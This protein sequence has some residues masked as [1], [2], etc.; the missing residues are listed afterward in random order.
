MKIK[1]VFK[2]KKK[3]IIIIVL[4][5][6]LLVILGVFLYLNNSSLVFQN[7]EDEVY[8]NYVGVSNGTSY[9]KDTADE[10]VKETAKNEGVAFENK[11][12]SENGL[13]QIKPSVGTNAL[14]FKILSKKDDMIKIIAFTSSNLC[15]LSYTV[16][17]I[18]DLKIVEE[19]TDGLSSAE[20]L[21]NKVYTIYNSIGTGTN[22]I[23]F[24]TKE[25]K[26]IDKTT[27]NTFTTPNDTY[28]IKVITTFNEKNEYDGM[29]IDY[30]LSL[31]TDKGVGFR[32]LK[33]EVFLDED[34][35]SAYLPL[36]GEY[37]TI[38]ALGGEIE[39]SYVE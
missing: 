15:N 33:S 37:M 23:F 10:K 24:F 38:Y 8:S 17:Q 13:L 1:N 4:V 29:E 36:K 5:C 22:T 16:G 19:G 26:F 11:T 39:L 12:K 32:C 30:C 25:G 28:Y 35:N 9:I 31:G 2:E 7:K 21:P 27:E 6:V 18:T 14:K 20:V 3:K 34:S